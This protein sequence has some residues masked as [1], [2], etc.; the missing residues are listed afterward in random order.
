MSQS[1]ILSSHTSGHIGPGM[2]FEDRQWLSWVGSTGLSSK[3]VMHPISDCSLWCQ[4]VTPH[5]TENPRKK[6]FPT[7]RHAPT[8]NSWLSV[9]IWGP[10]WSN[11]WTWT[12]RWRERN[13]W[14]VEIKSSLLTAKDSAHMPS[15]SLQICLIKKKFKFLLE[16]GEKEE[17]EKENNVSYW[18]IHK[19]RTGLII[20]RGARRRRQCTVLWGHAHHYSSEA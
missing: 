15:H 10:I 19:R 9:W 12:W 3:H 13:S 1:Q 20:I 16:R 2:S 7:F 18:S 11:V 6:S 17:E 14:S 8:I 5:H 4:Y